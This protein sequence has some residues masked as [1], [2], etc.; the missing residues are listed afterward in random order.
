MLKPSQAAN[1]DPASEV[2]VG[3]MR[4]PFKVVAARPSLQS[5]GLR[6]RAAWEALVRKM[7]AATLVAETYGTKDCS[8]SQR[9]VDEWKA[10]LK[11]VLGAAAPKLVKIKGKNVYTSP[12]D[13]EIIEAWVNKAGDPETQLHKWVR[14]GAPLGIEKPIDTCGIFPTNKGE[15]T[16]EGRGAMELSDAFSQMWD[17]TNYSSVAD[18]EPNARIELD[19]YY[20]QGYLKKIGTEEVE[21]NMGHGTVSKLGLI[22]K[23]KPSGEVKR[24]IIIDLKRSGGNDK[25][26]LP[27]K[28][29]LPRPRDAVE[30]MRDVFE[31]R[32]PFGSNTTYARELVVIDISDA[33]MALGVHP[34]EHPHT[35]AP[36]L[37]PDE[38]YLFAALLF[39]YKTA[40][41]L[42][43]RVA[44]L[45]ARMSQA[46]FR[47]HEAQ[48]QVYLDDGLWMLQGELE[49]RN[50]NLALILTTAAALGL[51]VALNKGER[52]PQTQWIG[53]RFALVDEFVI[54]TIPEKYVTE[55]IAKLRSWDNKGLAPLRE[56]RQAAGKI[57]WMSGLLPRTRWVVSVFYKVLHTRLNDIQDGTEDRRRAS[58]DDKRSKC[59]FFNVNQL[60]QARIWLIAYLETAMLKP[61][62][63]LRLDVGKYPKASIITD[64]SPE[65]LGAILLVNNRAVRIMA[66]RVSPQDSHELKFALGEASSQ[67]VVET[68]AVL[69]ALRLWE[70]DLQSCQV[71]MVLESDSVIALATSQRYSSSDP[72]LNFLG[73]E[74]SIACELAGIEAIHAR[75]IPG[76]AN[77]NADYLSRPSKWASTPRPSEIK[78]L[79][80]SPAPDREASFYRLPTPRA[81]PELWASNVAASNAWASLK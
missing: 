29:V 19:R 60:D 10:S 46:F 52:G 25:A 18:D 32:Q 40:P 73:A 79:P 61:S 57:S 34:E 17:A 26:T 49:E 14:E 4:D 54:L 35:L 70:R 42:W 64:A 37:D 63:K 2:Y 44:A 33:F 78:D 36:S 39:G 8:F 12:L 65:G 68:L 56:L 21:R 31:K 47:G 28:I 41:L 67:G 1:Q 16:S 75:H 30:M 50:S 43:S 58:R 15:S 5:T 3:G 72:A 27:E 22:V 55:L 69:V 51:K 20:D 45:W 24:R 77:V 38:F 13:P 71:T 81:K 23:E 74:I 7:P 9:V 80:L 62:R 66:S 76:S 48:H 6:I 59:N 53:I 11:R